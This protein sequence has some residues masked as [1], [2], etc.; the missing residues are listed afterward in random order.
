MSQRQLAVHLLE[1]VYK[2]I[3]R[4]RQRRPEADS[5]YVAWNPVLSI[6]RS[7]TKCTVSDEPKEV[8]G[9]GT[10]VPHIVNRGVP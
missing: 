5:L 1:E 10:V 3:L 7:L 2:V 8:V 9:T 6:D 4:R